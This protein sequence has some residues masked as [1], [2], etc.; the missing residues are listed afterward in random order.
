MSCFAGL[1]FCCV[2]IRCPS[3]LATPRSS[4]THVVRNDVPCHYIYMVVYV[5][6]IH[7]NIRIQIQMQIQMQMHTHTHTHIRT[8]TLFQLWRR[9]YLQRYPRWRCHQKGGLRDFTRHVLLF[10]SFARPFV[11]FIVIGAL[12]I[13]V[14]LKGPVFL[15]LP[16]CCAYSPRS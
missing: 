1:P 12:L 15:K 5:Y 9:H 6:Y 2:R 16:H 11:G 8:H 7:I 13:R 14:Y 4:L 3:C 10:A